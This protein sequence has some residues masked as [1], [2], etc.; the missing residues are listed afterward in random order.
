[1]QDKD[2]KFANKVMS[3]MLSENEMYKLKQKAA[4]DDNKLDWKLPLFYFN[5]AQKDL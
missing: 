5:T 3:I 2:V 1:M 4:W